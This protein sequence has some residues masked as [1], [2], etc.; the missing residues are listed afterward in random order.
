M[1]AVKVLW[2]RRQP[3]KK[4][5]VSRSVIA[6]RVDNDFIYGESGCRNKK[7]SHACVWVLW[8]YQ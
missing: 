4:T 2:P 3:M 8:G 1:G 6:I 5:L 7:T